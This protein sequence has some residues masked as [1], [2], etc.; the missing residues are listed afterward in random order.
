M[1]TKNK[2]III[3]LFTLALLP[4]TSSAQNKSILDYSEIAMGKCADGSNLMF[5]FI[6]TDGELKGF[7]YT[8]SI[9]YIVIFDRKGKHLYNTETL[10]YIGDLKYGNKELEQINNDGYL[11]YSK[12]GLFGFSY[13]KPTFYDFNNN[14]VW[15][16]KNEVLLSNRVCN[17]AIC[18]QDN[19]GEDLIAYNL[20]TGKELWQTTI[21][22][23]RH[24]P[25]GEASFD[26]KDDNI[27]YLMANSLV[28]LNMLTG[29]TICH[30][31]TAGIKEPTSSIFSFSKKRKI[32]GS[33]FYDDLIFSNVPGSTLTGTHS[34][35]LYSGDSIYVA[36]ANN[37]YCF[38]KNL[39]AIWTVAFPEG[40]G[41]NSEINIYG[42]KLYLQNFGVAFQHGLI[43]RYGKP[44][45]AVYNK[46]NGKQLSFVAP[47]I[48]PKITG[49]IFVKGRAYWQSDKK[50]FYTDEGD[51]IVHQIDWKPNTFSFPNDYY[52]DYVIYDTIG[53]V[54]KD[55][56]VYVPTNKDQLVMEVYGKDFNIIHSDG[57][58]ELLSYGEAY[59][60]SSKHEVYR[61]NNDYNK[62]NTSV[63]V[64]PK[65]M[66]VLY[67]FHL[68][69]GH[70]FQDK[71]GNIFVTTKQGVGFRQAQK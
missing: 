45:A 27:V 25:W 39:K 37:L 14:E 53:I 60:Y 69:N 11:A 55:T 48:E 54:K 31:F 36:D 56:M 64:D 2:I 65:T 22:F 58:C 33:Q 24:Y 1:K 17:V 44:F 43:G 5:H 7:L 49:G 67:S 38:D 59:P 26:N 70:V 18:T 32:Y 3:L 6:P 16:S 30:E 52:S 19:K 21:P 13:G 51:S 9:P 35:L 50:L 46:Y 47:N 29:D 28:R 42:D 63:I 15:S 66:K 4:F 71:T 68:S 8:D 40:M 62:Y 23:K 57:T 20:S 61:T 10:R 34:N 41:A 12:G